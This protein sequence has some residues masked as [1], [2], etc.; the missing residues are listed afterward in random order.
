MLHRRLISSAIVITTVLLLT[1]LDFWIGQAYSRT[2]C[3]L[4]VVLLSLGLLGG[5]ELRRMVP[6]GPQRPRWPIIAIAIVLAVMPSCVGVFFP[7]WAATSPL[8][9]TGTSLVGWA[10]ALG[11]AFL[12]SMIP[13]R[14]ESQSLDR[15]QR[16]LLIALYIGM[17]SFL[18]HLRFFGGNVWGLVALFSLIVTVKMSDSFAYLVGRAVGRRKLTPQL[19]PGKTVEGAAA[20]LVFGILG[21]LLVL[22]PIAYLV[23]GTIG[24]TTFLGAV[25]YGIVVTIVGIWGDLVESFIKRESN[26]KDSGALIPG[27]GGIL[28]V[29]D[30]ILGAAP[31]AYLLWGAGLVG[32]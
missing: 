6:P 12:S 1:W 27:M 5:E 3:V 8:G 17:L 11:W 18:A 32:P 21:S 30:S 7:D 4:A 29:I 20:A 19:S 14:P 16:I 15:A 9:L 22:F 23:T 13:Y 2:G 25:V 24:H 26:F 10:A 31:V 28:D